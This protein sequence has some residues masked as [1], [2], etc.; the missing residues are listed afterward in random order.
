M[1][2]FEVKIGGPSLPG[3]HNGELKELD[4]ELGA[5]GALGNL[6]DYFE[7]PEWKT[8]I[9]SFKNCEQFEKQIDD[10][11]RRLQDLEKQLPKK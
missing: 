6:H 1:K 4:V 9:E 8:R 10:L 2:P 11:E 5:L 7:S 3:M